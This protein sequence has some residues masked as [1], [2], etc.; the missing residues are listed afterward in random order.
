M[1]LFTW[2]K[3]PEVVEPYNESIEA[4][5]AVIPRLRPVFEAE[6]LRGNEPVGGW[7]KIRGQ[8]IGEYWDELVLRFPH[9]RDAIRAEFD[10]DKDTLSLTELGFGIP[11][12]VIVR[13]GVGVENTDADVARW[14]AARERW[15]TEWRANPRPKRDLAKERV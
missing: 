13:C 14:Q 5:Y 6:R 11:W 12:M 4:Q 7:H 3:R 8:Y 15:W 9:D 2:R 1:G 10:F